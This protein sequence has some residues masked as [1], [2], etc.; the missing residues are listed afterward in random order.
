MTFTPG[1][2]A[3]WAT[4]QSPFFFGKRIG[5][6]KAAAP[7]IEIAGTNLGAKRSASP[8]ISV[9]RQSETDESQSAQS[10]DTECTARRSRNQSH[11]PV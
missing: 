10:S 1:G 9:R 2:I 8:D 6:W 3:G 11:E 5:G 4:F 7:A